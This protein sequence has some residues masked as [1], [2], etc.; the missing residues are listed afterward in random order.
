[1]STKTLVKVSVPLRYSV[2]FEKKES[3]RKLTPI[4]ATVDVYYKK[5]DVNFDDVKTS[6]NSLLYPLTD[7]IFIGIE[8]GQLP[9]MLSPKN[10]MTIQ[11]SIAWVRQ[12][13]GFIDSGYYILG[14]E[15]PPIT[16]NG[17][18]VAVVRQEAT[19]EFIAEV[20]YGLL[21]HLVTAIRVTYD[22]GESV[23]VQATSDTQ[24]PLF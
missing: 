22:S 19:L 6:I 15:I 11:E 8:D 14:M 10:G 24:L 13:Q 3:S 17:V 9:Y 5:N 23:T 1:M 12:Q 21:K 16:A 2:R 4:A 18:K 7:A 20:I